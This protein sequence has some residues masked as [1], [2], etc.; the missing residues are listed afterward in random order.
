MVQLSPGL[1]REQGQLHLPHVTG[2]VFSVTLAACTHVLQTAV[3]TLKEASVT[4]AC[5]H[6][7]QVDMLGINRSIDLPQTLPFYQDIMATCESACAQAGTSL[8]EPQQLE[9]LF[10]KI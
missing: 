4:A 8:L 3:D 7:C 6:Q 1:F 5:V 9:Q 2:N 10:G